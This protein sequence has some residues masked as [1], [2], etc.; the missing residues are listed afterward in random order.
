MSQ[1]FIFSLVCLNQNSILHA[2][3]FTVILCIQNKVAFHILIATH[4]PSSVC[5]SKRVYYSCHLGWNIVSSFKHVV[6]CRE[7]TVLLQT[8]IIL[9]Q[10][11]IIIKTVCY[12]AA[13]KNLQ[14][15]INQQS[16]DATCKGFF[17]F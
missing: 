7:P 3:R 4:Q 6:Y 2:T 17:F 8:V 13:L 11:E 9:F 5:H 1:S 12:Y 14:S 16:L 10:I 15:S